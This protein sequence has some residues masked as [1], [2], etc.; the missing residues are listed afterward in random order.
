MGWLGTTALAAHQ[1]ALQIAA[2]LFMVPF[3]ISLAAT[4]R[5]GHAVGR[6][7]PAAARRAGFSAI[8]LGAAIMVVL[9]LIVVMF[10]NVIPLLF[11]GDAAAAAGETAWLAAALLLVGATWFI[12]DGIQGVAA[13]ALRGLNDTRVPM[14]YAAL[15]FWLVGFTSAYALAFWAGIGVFG[16]WIG[17]SLSLWL[18]AAVAD[19]AI[20]QSDRAWTPAGGDRDLDAARSCPLSQAMVERLTIARLGRRG[21]GIADTPDGAGLCAVHAARRNR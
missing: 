11:L 4:V 15:S 8:A 13:G 2:I 7:D 6:G 9:T 18:F 5:V 1:I 19:R 21:D 10:R 14:L 16:V 20:P 17:F 12:A 3:G